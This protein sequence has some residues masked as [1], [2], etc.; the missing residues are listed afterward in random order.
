MIFQ[1]AN[2]F[3]GTCARICIGLVVSTIILL[4]GGGG[5]GVAAVSAHSAGIVAPTMSTG[6]G[7]GTIKGA[8]FRIGTVCERR[9][10]AEREQR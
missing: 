5:H 4:G 8:A 2:V 6:S 9:S 7:S 3:I 10:R 1:L